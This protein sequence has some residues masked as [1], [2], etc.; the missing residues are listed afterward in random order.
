MPLFVYFP[1]GAAQRLLEF[2]PT[3]ADRENDAPVAI[4]PRYRCSM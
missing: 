1:W 2:R 3:G 4:L